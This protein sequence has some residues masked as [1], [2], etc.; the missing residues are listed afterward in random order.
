MPSL[1]MSVAHGLDQ[2]GA[3]RRLK[4]RF[5]AIKE[6]YREHIHGLQ[7]AWEQNV[8]TFGF[9]TFGVAVRGKVTA[10]PSEVKV[11]AELPL[12]AMIFKGTIEKQIRDELSRILA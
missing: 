11:V 6:T 2:E 1:S 4:D 8:L 9:T 5:D 7:E 12:T 3:T 10:E